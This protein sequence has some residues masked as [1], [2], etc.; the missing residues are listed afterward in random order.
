MNQKIIEK[1]LRSPRLPSLPTI[2]LEVIDL[3]HQKDVNI[4]QIAHTISHDPALSSKILKTVNSSFYGQQSAISTISHALV[5]LGLNAVKTLALGFCLVT[6]LKDSGG[7][8]FDH[9]LFWKRS[10]YSAVAARLLARQVG[11]VQQEE[12][13]LGGLLQDLGML[14]MNQTLGAEYQAVT[15]KA[16]SDHRALAPLE[17]EVFDCDH[18][19]VGA[20]L[21]E[22]WNL[23]PIL[24][25]PIRFHENAG[26][27]TG[28]LA[29]LV[30]VVSL[31]GRAADIFVVPNA[32]E[33]L[34][35]FYQL[36][37]EWFNLP[38]DSAEQLLAGINKASQEMRRLC[39]LPET[40]PDDADE[41]LSRANE[42][43]SQLNL[44]QQVQAN[45]LE[46]ENKHLAEQ[47][48]TDS[49][50]GA[51]NRRRFNEYIE[52][53]FALARTSGK[54]LSV[55]FLDTD[56]FKKFNDTYGHQTGDRVLMEVSSVLRK[57]SPQP[58]LVA[59]YGGEEFAVVLPATDRMTA[60][61]QA[62]LT[63]K[64]IQDA[65]VISDKNETLS[66]TA[67]IGVATF[68]GTVFA[69]AE[70]LVK[71]ADQGVY[72]AKASGRNCVHIFTPKVKPA[73]PAA[74]AT[75]VA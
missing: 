9:A 16:G 48:V 56:H 23:P 21:A 8:G 60:A 32:A 10:L 73:V 35:K 5:V 65:K 54:H 34:E 57:V 11:V 3:V 72:A 68:D 52:A 47:A 19:Q 20:A 40:G 26:N 49:L 39:E 7:E 46:K 66:V 74:A 27:I 15:N 25:K 43:L 36:A 63:R 64:A 37:T 62:E 6:N 41:I 69:R 50:T 13:F 28:E 67:S 2:A 22:K 55:L 44:Q 58:C 31:S 1:V 70:Q 17:T 61:K 14:A 38:R 24:C 12:A 4:K 75:K 59:R 42:A 30:K 29:P 71:A 51:A 45:V 53:E 18:G 33:A